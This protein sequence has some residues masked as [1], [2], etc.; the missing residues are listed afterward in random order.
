MLHQGWQN[1][2]GLSM[3][4]DFPNMYKK[5]VWRMIQPIVIGPQNFAER[6]RGCH[7]KIIGKNKRLFLLKEVFKRFFLKGSQEE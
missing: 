4:K 1:V 5:W 2:K 7:K 6:H 3:S